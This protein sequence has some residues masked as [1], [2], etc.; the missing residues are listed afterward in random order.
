MR[1]KK[2]IRKFG[3]NK[4]NRKMLL[5][6]LVRNVFVYKKI[7][8]SHA[9]AKKLRAVVDRIVSLAKKGDLA[10]RQRAI[11]FLNDPH[12]VN[13]IFSEADSFRNRNGGYTQIIK[14]GSRSGDGCEMSLIQLL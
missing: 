7:R 1:H 2:N 9:K 5:R 10:S 3:R 8:T 14:L 12:L 4:G 6:N 11:A 13:K